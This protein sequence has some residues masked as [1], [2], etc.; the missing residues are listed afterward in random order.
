MKKL[1]LLPLAALL[2]GGVFALRADEPPKKPQ[3]P[4]RF[5]TVDTP[6][7]WVADFKAAE[8]QTQETGL[9]LLILFTDSADPVCIKLRDTM[10]DRGLFQNLIS[11]RA[12]KLYVDLNLKNRKLMP[13]DRKA[14]KELKAK[15]K[16]EKL[17]T[18]IVIGGK[19][20]KQGKEIMRIVGCPGNY[21]RKLQQVI[22]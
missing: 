22:R 3:P 21:V 1:L 4:K 10:I 20:K 15:Y 13:Q 12:A 16:V 6:N 17:P 8:I 5:L 14:N 11:P 18:T 7:G 2:L 9:P 19:G